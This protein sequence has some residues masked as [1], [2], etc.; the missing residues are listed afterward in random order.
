MEYAMNISVLFIVAEALSS[1]TK[2]CTLKACSLNIED[3]CI[4]TNII[5]LLLNDIVFYFF[6]IFLDYSSH[7]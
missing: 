4:N 1:F 3:I 6:I 2:L 7:I 5:L